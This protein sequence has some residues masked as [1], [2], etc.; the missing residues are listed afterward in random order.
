MSVLKGYY[1]ISLYMVEIFH[2]ILKLLDPL[3]MYE[4]PKHFEEYFLLVL[5]PVTLTFIG[6]Y[7]LT[8]VFH[9]GG[10]NRSPVSNS[11]YDSTGDIILEERP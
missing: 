10:K 1:L 2:Y 11:D 3:I 8:H 9:R 6:R 4:S 7:I 5:R